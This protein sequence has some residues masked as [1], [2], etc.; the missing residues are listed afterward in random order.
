M[1]II[2]DSAYDGKWELYKIH[3]VSGKRSK[4]FINK[5]YS[6][7]SSDINVILSKNDKN[8]ISDWESNQKES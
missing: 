7:L 4:R 2:N 5:A 1:L 6:T 8:I 3:N